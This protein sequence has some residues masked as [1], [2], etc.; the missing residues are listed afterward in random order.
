MSTTRGLRWAR[1]FRRR[2]REAAR[3][4][5][6]LVPALGAL[7]GLAL[8]AVV[9]SIGG[10]ESDPWSVDVDRSRDTMIAALG[11]M[12]AALSIVLALTSVAAQNVVGR[13]GSRTLRIYARRSADRWIIGAFALA[14]T[15]ILSEQ[16]QLRKLEPDAPA[17]AAGITISVLLLVFTSSLMIWYIASVI[18]WF[19]VDQAVA[20]VVETERHAMRTV[21]RHRRGSSPTAIPERPAGAHD[22]LSPRSGYLAEFDTDMMLEAA[23]ALDAVVVITRPV[24]ATVFEDEPIGWFSSPVG[25]AP[26]NQVARQVDI[27]RT[28]ELAQSIEYGLYALVDIAIMALSPAVNDPNSAVE[29]IEEMSF[30]FREI[31]KVRLGPYAIPD[32]ESVPRVVVAA[33]TFGELVELATT[34]IVLYGI[35]DPSVVTA[36]RRFADSFDLMDLEDA[37]QRAVDEFAAKLDEV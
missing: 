13:F 30:L 22:L 11:L 32:T 15:F 35:N 27:A 37:D 17:P 8:S 23:R 12:F 31:D 26:G 14:A 9:N 36:L 4:N 28:R 6:W 2:M 3:D 25:A 10:S 5:Q 7:T 29:V 16:F 19:R 20:G 1:R 24:G 21:T 33:R 18:R 34:Q